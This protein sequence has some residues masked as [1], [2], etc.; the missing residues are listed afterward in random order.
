MAE[1]KMKDKT[2]YMEDLLKFLCSIYPLSERCQHYL[3]TIVK[4]R[5][6]K[7]GEIILR[8]GQIDRYMSYVEKGLL[9]AYYLKKSGKEVTA[10]FMKTGDV[11]TDVSS[12]YDQVPSSKYIQVLEDTDIYYITFDELE[13]VYNTFPEF[14]RIGRILITHY[15]KLWDSIRAA[16]I[17]QSA[18]ERYEWMMENNPELILRV[19]AKHIAAFLGITEVTLSK[20]KRKQAEKTTAGGK[21]LKVE[22]IKGDTRTKKAI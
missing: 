9:R 3:R 22:S 15:Y 20:L 14:D 18:K 11:I 17:M 8:P 2:V 16:I 12:F 7:K 10:W 21:P 19:S 5:H 6:L 13:Y 4:H 1:F